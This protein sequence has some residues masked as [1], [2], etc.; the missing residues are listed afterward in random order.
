[1]QITMIK[2]ALALVCALVILATSEAGRT[3]LDYDGCDRG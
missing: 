1:M 2:L 3:L